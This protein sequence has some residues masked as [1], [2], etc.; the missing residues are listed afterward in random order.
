MKPEEATL[1]SLISI[2]GNQWHYHIPKYQRE[3][4]WGKYDWSKLIEDIYDSDQ[5]HYMGSIICVHEKEELTPSGELIYDVV[6]GQQRLTTISL[7]LMAIYYKL[8]YELLEIDPEI[9]TDADYKEF[10]NS[11]RKKLIKKVKANSS[12]TPIGGFRS[13]GSIIFLR[14]QPSSQFSNLDDYKYILSELELIEELEKPRN[15]GNR[16]MYKAYNYFYEHIPNDWTS[17]KDLLE[18]VN[19]LAFILISETSHS[20]AFILFETLNNRKMPLSGIDIIKNK[21]L[22]ILEINHGIDIDESYNQWQKLLE[23]LPTHEEQDRYLRQ[24]Y[25]AFKFRNDIK[26]EKV[27]KATSSTLIKIYET[28]IHKNANGIFNELKEKA[29]IYN[30]LIEPEKYPDTRLNQALIDLERIGATP[31]YTFLLYLFNLKKELFNESNLLLMVVNLLCKYYLRRNVTDF[32]NTRDLDAINIELIEKCQKQITHSGK[33]SYSFIEKILLNGKGSPASIKDLKENLTDNLFYYNEG[34]ARYL[35]AKLDETAHSR[36]YKPDLW[37]RNEKKLYVWTVEHIFPQ[38]KNIPREW[39]NMIG[40]G[41]KEKA[42]EIQE[43]W[44]HCLGNLTLSGYNSKLS[45]YSF[46]KKQSR[47]EANIFG[48]KIKIG[49]KNGLAINNIEFKLNGKK[50]NLTN[51]KKWQKEMIEARNN[52]MVKMILKLFAFKKSELK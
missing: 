29:K 6:D 23:N 10:L 51:V 16:I 33:L 40:D 38:G 25:N 36:E 32:P 26:V 13:N 8:K 27:P 43:N 19:R 48:K 42:E 5:G 18:R 49:Y 52:L 17:L 20:K 37:S 11:I 2:E 24:F 34:M 22:A 1:A 9:E 7:L 39:I 47:S 41:D 15:C 12:K 4:I 50:F 21:M 46:S 3:Y 30:Q 14:V 44:V 35:L 45:T 28:L 31:C